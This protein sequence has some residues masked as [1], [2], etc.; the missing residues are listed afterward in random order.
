MNF[1]QEL[2]EDQQRAVKSDGIVV[3]VA[4][5]GTG[6]TK[7]L[8]A[9]I[10]YLVKVK[11][12][13]PS[14]ILALTFTKKAATEMKERLAHLSKKPYISTFHALATNLLGNSKKIISED[15]RIELLNS[16]LKLNNKTISK[17]DI[18][19]ASLVITRHKNNLQNESSNLVDTYNRLLI[20]KDLID[21]DDL[22]LQ[23]YVQLKENKISCQFSYILVDEF[24]DTNT[25][26][27]EIIKL[28]LKN[29]E[30]F[31]IG[32]PLQS[33][34]SFRGANFDIFKKIERDFPIQKK[35][36]LSINYRS[37]NT[38]IEASSSL[39]PN[40]PKLL[41]FSKQHGSVYHIAT[42]NEYTEAEWI[43][44]KIDTLI[45]GTDLLKAGTNLSEQKSKL[46]FKDFAIIY[47]SHT[48]GRVL[49]HIFVTSS[50]PYQIIGDNTLYD[51]PEIKCIIACLRYL[52]NNSAALLFE[53]LNSNLLG[54]T[55]ET[56][57]QLTQL[58]VVKH[59]KFISNLEVNT[60]LYCRSKKD[61]N[62]VS[63]F[64]ND[65][66]S[67]NSELKKI[68]LT[69]IIH[70]IVN[71]KIIKEYINS[72]A[73]NHNNIHMFISI[74]TQFN[75]TKNGLDRAIGYLDYLEE[76]E[77]YDHNIDKVSLM[78]IHA[79]KGLEFSE[80][81]IVGVEEGNIPLI[82]KGEVDSIDEEKR[83]LYVAMTRA[84]HNLYLFS[85][86]ERGK[87]KTDTSQ[88]LTHLKC[89]T[90]IEDEAI[91][92]R[93]KLQKKWKDKKSQLSLF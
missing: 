4:G 47:R 23:L 61:M 39:F 60:D 22:L 45:G 80:V 34:Y 30:L 66:K 74:F 26:Q 1:L 36:Q 12:I 27:Y 58:Y 13:D 68:E 85:A 40:I 86:Q 24:Q 87:K 43:V 20:E 49:E 90:H 16:A 5:P 38:I 78:T 3:I 84:K 55:V 46:S 92:K 7:T 11:H 14:Q 6:K 9:R 88:F 10:Q 82:K 81:F 50:I 52:Q 79:A 19:N 76:H 29:N 21:Y 72:K 70:K 93:I 71:F 91:E 32:D 57:K 18:K 31:V 65:L 42:I 8:T 15:K 37:D 54:L 51:K 53:I 73:L 44:S 59:D 64:L 33:I 41:S 56:K 35:I 69:E 67:I 48:F 17:K 2:N 75:T 28:L 63:T 62:L 83:L 25:L 77:F 89:I